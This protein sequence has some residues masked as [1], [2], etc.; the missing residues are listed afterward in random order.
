[1]SFV[2]TLIVLL[3]KL[4][5]VTPFSLYAF[6]WLLTGILNMLFL[7]D[8]INKHFLEFITVAYNALDFPI[9]TWFLYLSTQ[10][11]RLRRFIQFGL[12]AFIIFELVCLVMGGMHYD[13]LKYVLGVGV[14]LV[15]IIVIWQIVLYLQQ[16]EYPAKEKAL[17]LINASLLFYYG[18][19]I[20]VYIFDYFAVQVADNDDKFLIYYISIIISV[21]ISSFALLIKGLQKVKE[22]PP[23][24]KK[25]FW[26]QPWERPVQ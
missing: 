20:V 4:W 16:M 6:Y 5:Q 14:I 3:K 7:T 18:T 1:M 12:S 9:M 22:T 8:G 11:K 23:G 17:L 2:P 26:V 15:M 24:I 25:S 19:Y 21:A 10:S 13:S